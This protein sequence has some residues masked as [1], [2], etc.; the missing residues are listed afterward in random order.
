MKQHVF[1]EDQQRLS[2]EDL[3]EDASPTKDYGSCWKWREIQLPYFSSKCRIYLRMLPISRTRDPACGLDKRS[4]PEKSYYV[5]ESS[6][7][8]GLEEADDWQQWETSH[9]NTELSLWY[10]ESGRSKEWRK[11]RVLRMKSDKRYIRATLHI[12][13]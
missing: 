3:W 8:S 9:G 1:E 5:F 6:S 10:E 11:C 12:Q 2:I 7:R 4:V 13:L